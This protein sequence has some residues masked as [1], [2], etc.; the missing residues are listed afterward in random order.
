M[1]KKLNMLITMG[2]LF[3]L[4]NTPLRAQEPFEITIQP[5]SISIG[6]F[7]DGISLTISGTIPEESEAVAVFTGNRNVLHLKEKGKALGLLWMN[8][9]SLTYTNVPDVF[10]VSSRKRIEDMPVSKEGNNSNA[11]DIGLEGLRRLIT[12]ESE[13]SDPRKSIEE[14]FNLKKHE[15]L[16]R[17]ET[18]D[19]F[20]T[21]PAE[22]YKSFNMKVTIPSRLSPG[23]YTLYVYAVKNGQIIGLAQK[24]VNAGL[25]GIPA[26]LATLAFNH[27]FMY[28]ILAT[29][30]A[31]AGGL[32]VGYF[33]RG[34]KEGAH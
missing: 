28:G 27:S 18:E 33:F 9:D 29:I 12:V 7:Y 1:M 17:E 24:H 30:I 4:M 6:T 31:I 11:A 23:D 10:L 34:A 26:F 3:L 25:T 15:G 32:V 16:Y 5:Q 20:Y 14:L 2:I 19:I 22:G 8:L 21:A 13:K